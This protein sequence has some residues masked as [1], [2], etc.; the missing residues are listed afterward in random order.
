MV[1][2]NAQAFNIRIQ[3]T[4]ERKE[5]CKEKDK[6]VSR[7]SQRLNPLLP[8]TAEWRSNQSKTVSSDLARWAH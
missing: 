7:L 2:S 4:A 6:E 8:L 1:V 5:H 3:T